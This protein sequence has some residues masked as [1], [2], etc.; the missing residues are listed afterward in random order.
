MQVTISGNMGAL[1][2]VLPV[3]PEGKKG[4]VYSNL[5]IKGK[6]KKLAS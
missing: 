4:K 5:L 3:S 1:V 6:K 2:C